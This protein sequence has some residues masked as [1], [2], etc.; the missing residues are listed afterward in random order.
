MQDNLLI[1]GAIV[2]AAI[3]IG[4]A[5]YAWPRLV[6][7]P[8]PAVKSAP[9][10][11]PKPEIPD[12][13]IKIAEG[14][15]PWLHANDDNTWH[16]GDPDDPTWLIN[17]VPEIMRFLIPEDP[18][19]VQW[20]SQTVLIIRSIHDP[21]VTGF[22]SIKG[23]SKAVIAGEQAHALSNALGIIHAAALIGVTNKGECC[24]YSGPIT[25]EILQWWYK[26][27]MIGET[28]EGEPAY[29]VIDL[30]VLQNKDEKKTDT[31][32]MAANY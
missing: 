2:I 18:R 16:H 12:G 17:S 19:R 22:A 10:Q 7:R 9:Q 20:G 27:R 24:V 32:P 8:E 11:P 29:A 14:T 21:V 13:I 5:L 31:E 15:Q 6:K 25:G 4:C 26:A 3:I 30:A 1:A 23:P 28:V